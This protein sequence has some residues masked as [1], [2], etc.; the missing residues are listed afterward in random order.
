MNSSF[1]FRRSGALKRSAEKLNA[2]SHEVSTPTTLSE[3][4]DYLREECYQPSIYHIGPSW[5]H[6]GDTFC[7]EHTPSGYE[8]FY[9]ERGQRSDPIWIES[10]EASACRA[11]IALLDGERFSRSHCIAFTK[12]RSEIE[13]IEQKL[14][15]HGVQSTRNDIPAFGGPNDPRYRLFVTGRD[16][17][18]V[19]QLIASAQIPPVSL[20]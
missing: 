16:K 10:S 9:V 6:C 15:S 4:A 11:F 7:I 2:M 3:L 14:I 8:S 20:R 13:A 17:I 12:G 1:P 19:D 5:S 18:I